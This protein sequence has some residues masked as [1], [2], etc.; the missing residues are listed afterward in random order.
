MRVRHNM[1]LVKIKEFKLTRR[2]QRGAIISVP[3]V[4]LEENGV[5]F[6]DKISFLRN[7]L[8]NDLILR[9]EKPQEK[10][11]RDEV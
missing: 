1:E 4:W 3:L 5:G 10:E 6:G 8:D 11:S 7:P 9:I 2:G